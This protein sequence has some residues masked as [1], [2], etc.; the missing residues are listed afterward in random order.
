M[1]YW[2]SGLPQAVLAASYERAYK[3]AVKGTDMDMGP[4]RTRL[5]TS[6]APEIVRCA[7]ELNFDRV[8]R[9]RRFFEEETA[10][11]SKP[12]IIRDQILDG[13]ALEAS[14]GVPLVTAGGEPI[15]ISSRWLVMFTPKQPPRESEP[16][17]REIRISFSLL[18][19]P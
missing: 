11:G 12:F 3:D 19:L 4:P 5:Q 16:R 13:L 6:S 8:P 15:T 17:G 7:I 2:P 1:I 14:P 10:L 9:F 18:I